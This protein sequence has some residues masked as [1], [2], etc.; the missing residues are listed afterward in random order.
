MSY[1]HSH[2]IIHRDLKPG[3]VFL[4]KSLY[5]K[6]SGFNISKF[7]NNESF[8]KSYKLKGTP[9]YLAPEVYLNHEYSK[10]SD[11]YSY[12]LI[13]YEI[14]TGEKPFDE[15]ISPK[16]IKQMICD[17]K[18]RPK[19]T[20][21]ISKAYCDLIQRCWSQNPEERPSFESILNEFKTNPD[22]IIDQ[23]DKEE[24]FNYIKM[25]DESPISFDKSKQI[26][27]V[28]QVFNN[29]VIGH[30][31]KNSKI[32]LSCIYDTETDNILLNHDFINIQ[33]YEKQKLIDVQ[34]MFKLNV[35]VDKQTN[36]L[37]KVKRAVD[38]DWYIYFVFDNEIE[39]LMELKHHP[40]FL[41]FVGFSPFDF[42]NR[43]LPTLVIEHGSNGTLENILEL[44]IK[45]PNDLIL[46]PTK[47]LIIIYGIASGMSYLHSINRI[48]CELKPTNIHLDEFLFPR[49][50]EFKESKLSS[51]N[52]IPDLLT[53]SFALTRNDDDFYMSPEDFIFGVNCSA[54]DVYSFAMIAYQLIT[55][56]RPFEELNYDLLEKVYYNNI[57]PKF[58]EN[59]PDCYKNLIEKCWP[60]NQKTD[61]HSMKLFII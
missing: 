34:I 24:Y 44:D 33:N 8:T 20:E 26:S 15:H 39:L 36:S 60:L 47:R 5:P 42:K 53:L 57:R 43:K 48:H 45:N 46:D 10:L 52:P 22:F 2:G 7:V 51:E 27:Y 16:E 6:L 49:I 38:K 41:N 61:Q 25:I 29:T 59:V 28:D 40:S 31:R 21:S 58:K 12:G 32:N 17:E 4:D 30:H 19:L 35:I 1:L 11:V 50:S 37:Y 23:I 55:N 14:I 13:V 9:A 54:S 3:N 56:E 18:R